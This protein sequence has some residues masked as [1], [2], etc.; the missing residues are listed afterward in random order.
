MA[1]LVLVIAEG[2]CAVFIGLD[3]FGSSS[4]ETQAEQGCLT[5]GLAAAAF[6]PSQ[7]PHGIVKNSFR[8]TFL[9]LP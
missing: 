3:K 1:F 7:C 5:Q 9:V 6:T 4:L 2:R 8:E